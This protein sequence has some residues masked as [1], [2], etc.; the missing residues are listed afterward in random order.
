MK[1]IFRCGHQSDDGI[2]D[3]KVRQDTRVCLDCVGEGKD[4]TEQTALD[5]E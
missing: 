3:S 5:W 2:A 4:D 1:I